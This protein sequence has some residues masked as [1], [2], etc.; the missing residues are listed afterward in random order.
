M[1]FVS[2]KKTIFSVI[3]LYWLM[4]DDDRF[5]FAFQ[6]N[7]LVPGRFAATGQRREPLLVKTR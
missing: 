1:K 3:Y 5:L 2:P 7:G 6:G 4:I